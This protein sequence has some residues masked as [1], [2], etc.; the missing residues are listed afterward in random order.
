MLQK[1]NQHFNKARENLKVANDE[2]FK[3]KEDVVTYLVCKNSQYAIENNL[4]GFLSLR[5]FETHNHET[6]QGLLKRCIALD[7]KFK[8][9]DLKTIDCRAHLID[10]TYC[11]DVNQVNSCFK[12]ADDLDT[13]LR[14][15]NI[16]S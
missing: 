2:L 3:P 1:S 14:Q 16:I 8:N 7:S 6:L 12:T 11:D 5:G 4:K 15:L 9:I 13:F 10:S